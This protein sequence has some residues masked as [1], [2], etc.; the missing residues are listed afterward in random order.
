MNNP[1]GTSHQDTDSILEQAA[2]TLDFSQ[3]PDGRPARG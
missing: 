3:R 1:Q 2:D